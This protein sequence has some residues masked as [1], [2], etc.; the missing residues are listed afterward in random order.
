MG[1]SNFIIRVKENLGMESESTFGKVGEEL[2]VV[3]GKLIDKENFLWFNKYNLIKNID[4]INDFFKK[5][6][7]FRTVFELVE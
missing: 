3:D 6:D 4:D 7:I 1:E 5:K 2:E